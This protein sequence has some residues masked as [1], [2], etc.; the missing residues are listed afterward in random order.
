MTE[1]RFI[2]TR[3]AGWTRLGVPLAMASTLMTP[4]LWSLC[5]FD[6]AANPL[7]NA[8]VFGLSATAFFGLTPIL[9][10]WALRGFLVRRKHDDKTSPDENPQSSPRAAGPAA[11]PPNKRNG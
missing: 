11:I 9:I 2:P 7:L 5:V 8:V 1:I 10:G 3:A 4:A 6:A